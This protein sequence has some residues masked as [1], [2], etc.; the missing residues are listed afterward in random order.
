MPSSVAATGVM[1]GGRDAGGPRIE[2]ISLTISS[3]GTYKRGPSSA[4]R[5]DEIGGES[6][7]AAALPGSTCD[8]IGDS[9]SP[10][11]ALSPAHTA[12][13]LAASPYPVAA[14]S[15]SATAASPPSRR[16][17]RPSTSSSVGAPTPMY[18]SEPN[19]SARPVV[20]LG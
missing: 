6:S 2:A 4:E 10:S 14:T 8:G 17:H 5:G 18:S 9:T 11:P 15:S 20:K 13:S 19:G 1:G 3:V 7:S 12:F 16:S